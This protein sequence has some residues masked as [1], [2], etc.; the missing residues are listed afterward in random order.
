MIAFSIAPKVR[1]VKTDCQWLMVHFCVSPKLNLMLNLSLWIFTLLRVSE[2]V[3][4]PFLSLFR[5]CDFTA[6]TGL[7]TRDLGYGRSWVLEP[8]ISGIALAFLTA[9]FKSWCDHRWSGVYMGRMIKCIPKLATDIH[10]CTTCKL[11]TIM[12][13]C[14]LQTR[15]VWGSAPPQATHCSSSP[16]LWRSSAWRRNPQ[17]KSL[18]MFHNLWVKTLNAYTRDISKH[19]MM[20]RGR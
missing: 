15:D 17:S 6:L 19:M 10:Q 11:Q 16:G 14:F 20:M 9:S 1:M 18:L 2:A 13:Q 7:R 5:C 4:E 12:L 8:A 3:S